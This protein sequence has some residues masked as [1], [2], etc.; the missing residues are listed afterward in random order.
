[1]ESTEGGSLS[2]ERSCHKWAASDRTS[3]VGRCLRSSVSVRSLS[4]GKGPL[5]QCELHQSV[6][7][8]AVGR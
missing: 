8:L 3:G 6:Y 5:A 2:D 4:F 1:M 7:C